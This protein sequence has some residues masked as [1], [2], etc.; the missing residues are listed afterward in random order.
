MASVADS[1]HYHA[2]KDARRVGQARMIPDNR[3]TPASRAAW[4]AGWDYQ[5]EQ[6]RPPP[7]AEQ[8]AAHSA[9]CTDLLARLAKVPTCATRSDQ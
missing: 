7:T 4:Y 2:G 6:M 9:F 5:N 8:R 1:T 3:L